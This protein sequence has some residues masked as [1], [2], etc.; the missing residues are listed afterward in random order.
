[1]ARVPGQGMASSFLRICKRNSLNT[2]EQRCAT[3]PLDNRERETVINCIWQQW[4]QKNFNGS[5]GCCLTLTWWVKKGTINTKPC[6]ILQRMKQPYTWRQ[7]LTLKQGKGT[8]NWSPIFN[9]V[10][11]CAYLEGHCLGRD[12]SGQGLVVLLF[13]WSWHFGQIHMPLGMFLRGGS[14]Q[15]RW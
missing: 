8:L 13:T 3:W 2:C 15:S 9:I 5:V 10:K 4:W 12:T 1:M 7:P 14:R 11:V 6:E